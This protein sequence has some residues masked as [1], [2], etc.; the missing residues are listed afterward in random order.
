MVKDIQ[1]KNYDYPLPDSF[2]PR[3]PLR[4]RDACRLIVSKPDG[5][6]LHKRFSDLT[7]LLKQEK[8]LLV[9]NDTRVINARLSFRKPTGSVVEVFLLEPVEPAD[10]V[11]MF[12]AR[13][14]CR[15]KCMV[16]NLKRW[17]GDSLD[18]HLT[19]DN[20]EVVLTAYKTDVSEGTS[21]EII[22]R[23]SEPDIPFSTVIE[24]A[25]YIPIPPYLKRDA[26]EED[27]EDYQTVFSRFKGSVA[28]PTAGLHFTDQLMDE[29][30]SEGVDIAHVT[31]HVG[32][33]TFLPVK[34]ESIGE[35]LMHTE[36]FTVSRG[37][38]E[39]LIAA[40]ES[41]RPVLAVGTTTVRTLESLPYLGRALREGRSPEV[42]QWEAYEPESA[43]LASVPALKDILAKMDKYGTD[44]LTAATSIMIAPGFRWRIV[45][46]LV[47]NFHQPQSTLLL[48]VDS[49][50]GDAEQWKRIYSAALREGYRFLSYGDACLLYPRNNN[51]IPD[52]PSSKSI[53]AR[54]LIAGFMGGGATTFANMPD[55]DDTV[56]LGNALRQLSALKN[57][58][59]SAT[60]GDVPM[61]DVGAGGTTLRFLMAAV[62]ATP[63]LRVALTGSARLMERPVGKLVELLKEMGAKI[64]RKEMQGR[65]CWVISGKELAG[66][67]FEVD[68]SCSSQFVSALM[69]AA[70][71]FRNGLLLNLTGEIVS[72]PYI[73]MTAEVMRSFG[74]DVTISAD[75]REIRVEPKGYESPELFV[76]EKDWSSASYFF[77]KILIEGG[78]EA[79]VERLAHSMRLM[80]LTAPCDSLQ[81]DSRALELFGKLAESDRKEVLEID[82]KDT[83]DL[84]PALVVAAVCLGQPFSFS[85]LHHLAIKESDRGTALVNEMAKLGVTLK[86]QAGVLSYNGLAAGKIGSAGTMA[87]GKEIEISTYDDHR[88]A[89]AFAPVSSLL[90]LRIENPGV[91]AKS[92]PR[93]W[94]EIKKS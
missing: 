28:A 57:K 44:S 17:K 61:I 53:A 12:Q 88:I 66:G 21:R 50:L 6:I 54:A 10:Y 48:L 93:Y 13:G 32:A 7:Q 35:H 90:P 49:F 81:G 72:T 33:G 27:R 29:L 55:C 51:R 82:L 58:G 24:Q 39:N 8:P 3:H 89:M 77:E 31:L 73:R 84:V 18:M 64:E 62:A 60:D 79:T 9:C 78:E 85:G 5:E 42:I 91:V 45:S 40:L 76:I 37:L 46:R 22:F 56:N 59:T 4:Q 87:G 47:T 70:P 25:G 67:R 19:I 15:W 94:K 20:R 16:G 34:S 1:I 11:L 80:G 38:L 2:I 74:A 36:T 65:D 71:T 92:F 23:W 86:M 75:Y 69:L 26:Q 43:E 83:P 41:G 30:R 68:A 63:G 14:E 52:L